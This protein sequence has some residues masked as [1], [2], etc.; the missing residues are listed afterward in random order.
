MQSNEVNDWMIDR[1]LE[2]EK[3]DTKT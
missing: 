3:S 1:V 2:G